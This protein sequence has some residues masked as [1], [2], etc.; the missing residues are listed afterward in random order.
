MR[1]T[2]I[3]VLVALGLVIAS[4][5]ADAYP[6]FQ[7]STGNDTCVQCHF[8]PAGGG[9]INDY[10]R[11]EAGSTL[12]MR[13]G[14]GG[15]LHGVWTPPAEFQI[16]VD[17]RGVAGLRNTPASGVENLIFP[18]Q[19]ELYLRPKIGPVSL[20][21]N[22]GARPA[23]GDTPVSPGSREHYLMYESDAGWYLRAGRFFPVFGIRTQDHTAYVRRHMQMY[24]YEEP[25]GLAWGKQS[26]SSE[27]HVSAYTMSPPALGT[28]QDS[29]V[30]AYWERRNE[31]STAAYALQTR[32]SASATDQHSWFGGIYKRY[33]E[34]SKLMLLAELDLGMQSFFGQPDGDPRAQA[35]GYVSATY[36]AMQGLMIG[37]GLQVY[38][39]DITLE[40]SS[41]EA[42]EL[43]VQWFPIPHFELHL[44]TRVE[45]VGLE[46]GDP[47]LLSL[48]Q[49]H[50][51][52]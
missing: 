9:L 33:M 37:G 11:D 31:E 47:I 41:R 35:V 19:M 34:S 42:V 10:G 26:T 24:I 32:L 13:E 14:N 6:Q 7:F 5:R 28:N 39:P 52:L 29:G 15:F 18:M 22:V 25:Y 50:Y 3:A 12:S 2:C 43:N 51:Y 27:I 36:F 40:Q 20:Y 17:L 1:V 21:V 38:D 23:R 30:A 49:L 48:L 4:G 16:G 8:S 46:V 44:L 45:A